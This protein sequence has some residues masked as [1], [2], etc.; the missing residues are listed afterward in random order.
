[1]PQPMSSTSV[2][3][4]GPARAAPRRPV[5][6]APARV[7]PAPPPGA[8]NALTVDV[9][10][11][12]HVEAFAG[13]IDRDDWEAQ[14]RRVAPNTN[15]LLDIFGESGVTAT[16]FMLGWVAQRHP[17]LVRRIVAE[18]HELASHGSDHYRADRQSHDEFRNDVRCCKTLLEDIGGVPILGYRAPTFS[19]GYRNPWVHAV[20]AEEG[21]R[22][23]SSVYPIAHDLYGEPDAPRRPFC[24][25]PGFIEI[26][27]T[28]VRMFGRNLPSAGGGY[29]RLLPYRLTRW[30]LRRAG[31]ELH[32]PCV[33]YLHPW[34]IDPDQPRQSHAP[35][36]SRVRHYLN[37]TR[38]EGRLRRL[39]RDFS[40]ARMDRVFL[41][42][43]LPHP[44]LIETWL[45]PRPR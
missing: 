4:E 41:D 12:F 9:E 25:Q 32:T 26:P 23:S 45:N 35:R 37:L 16:F 44:P 18:G 17:D 20:L 43:A 10:D 8:C 34:E 31:K 15:R 1:M 5:G 28:T 39:L 6:S 38:T 33:F 11:Y 30:A 19:V 36:L 7:A 40:W 14:P 22:Y 27:L 21:Y 29:F 42:G 3:R 13:V 24:P 2:A